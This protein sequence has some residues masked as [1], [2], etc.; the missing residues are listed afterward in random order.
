MNCPSPCRPWLCLIVATLAGIGVPLQAGAQTALAPR[1]QTRGLSRGWAALEA[2]RF[3]DAVSVA[4]AAL[5]AFPADHGAVVLEMEALAQSGQVAAA[6]EAYQNWSSKHPRGD[7]SLTA[8]VAVAVLRALGASASPLAVRVAALKTLAEAGD[9]ASRDALSAL[10]PSARLDAAETLAALG[11]AS[12]ASALVGAIQDTQ[13]SRKLAAMAAA[14]RVHAPGAAEAISPMTTDRDPAIRAGAAAALGEL[15]NPASADSL[16]ALLKDPMP[17]VNGSAAIALARMGRPE[18]DAV[19]SQMLESGVPDIV[20]MAAEGLPSQPERWRSAVEPLL[21]TESPIDRLRAARLLKEFD[22]S[23]ASQAVSAA[24][25]DSNPAVREEA[26]RALADMGA[27]DGG[28]DWPRLL[29][30][31]SPSV[32][33]GA[34]QALMRE[35]Q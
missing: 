15:K 13:G 25:A 32:R 6:F 7:A 3:D 2:G 5:K 19:L 22:S 21:R 20:L 8:I 31:S 24:L 16:V 1:A 29:T 23:A 18:G 10:G 17:A 12:A 11:D 9:A 30:D 26:S 33:L 34:A 28:V 35:S 14:A 4:R 27:L